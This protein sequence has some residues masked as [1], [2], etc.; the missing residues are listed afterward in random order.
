MEVKYQTEQKQKEIEL[1]NREKQIASI[2][3]KFLAG[4]AIMMVIISVL[5]FIAL[6]NHRKHNKL[7]IQ[8]N[9]E[10][11]RQN[12]EIQEQSNNLS[13]AYHEISLQKDL[14]EKSHL[15]ITDSI[16][17]AQYIQSAAMPSHDYLKSLLPDH[18]IM[19]KPRDVVSGDFYFAKKIQNR[20]FLAVADCTGHGVPGAFMSMLGMAILN[21]L[22][23][24][25]EIENAADVLNL[26]RDQVKLSLQQKGEFGEQREG[27]DMALCII[28]ED[29]R[30]LSFSGA[31]N[32]LWLFR[33]NEFIEYRANRQP[34]GIYLKE[35]PFTEY[36]IQLKEG[37]KL[38]MFSDGF[39]S[40]FGGEHGDKLKVK[41][42]QQILTEV[43]ILPIKEQEKAL[44]AR[45]ENWKGNEIQIDD[46]LVMGF[47]V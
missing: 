36:K 5:I 20:I 38:Y 26:M 15:K 18:F 42:F 7:L 25:T 27:I 35:Q 29:N 30:E 1:L 32:P 17:Y 22:V 40:Q 31:Y 4:L 14:I 23:R 19:F 33:N 45:Y 24:R 37:D 41:R 21:E 44:I 34:V 12:Q 2:R 47:Q 43:S 11:Y 39:Y 13:D 6:F 16:N 3:S 28:S 8:K 10:I 9:V 46:I